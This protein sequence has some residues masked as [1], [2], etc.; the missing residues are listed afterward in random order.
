MSLPRLPD[1]IQLIKK[2]GLRALVVD[3]DTFFRKMISQKLRVLDVETLE[4]RNGQDAL[5]IINMSQKESLTGKFDL[6]FVDIK[7]PKMNG[8]EFVTALR[9]RFPETYVV[10]ITGYPKE[11]ALLD[12]LQNIE[13]SQILSKPIQTSE[14]VEI[15]NAVKSK[16]HE[17]AA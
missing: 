17:T 5:Q 8:Y 10:M 15:I 1:E 3:D 6:V 12:D 14:L 13:V 11:K 4:A 9:Q 7:M 2:I 16:T